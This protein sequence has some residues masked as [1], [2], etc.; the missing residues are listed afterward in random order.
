MGT[1]FLFIVISFAMQFFLQRIFRLQIKSGSVNTVKIKN[2]KGC[3]THLVC[4]TTAKK[5]IKF[6]FSFVYIII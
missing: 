3:S 4:E 2:C 1:T 6:K 5:K